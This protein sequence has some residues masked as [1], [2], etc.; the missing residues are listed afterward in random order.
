MSQQLDELPFPKMPNSG[1]ILGQ[2]HEAA[3][4]TS[5]STI[6]SGGGSPHSTRSYPSSEIDESPAAPIEGKRGVWCTD[7]DICAHSGQEAERA[8]TRWEPGDEET[9]LAEMLEECPGSTCYRHGADTWD[10]FQANET[11]FGV[12]STYKFDLSQYSTPLDVSKVPAR[13]RQKAERLAREIEE[14]RKGVDHHDGSDCDEDEEALWSSVPRSQCCST[15]RKSSLLGKMCPS[16]LDDI[17]EQG[18]SGEGSNSTSTRCTAVEFEQQKV[19][20]VFVHV[21]GVGIVD[22]HAV[23]SLPCFFGQP[24]YQVNAVPMNN[25]LS[26]AAPSMLGVG[27]VQM[28]NVNQMASS[29]TTAAH[30]ANTL[31]DCLPQGTQVVIDGLTKAPAFNGRSGV[32]QSFD[33]QSGR[34]NLQLLMESGGYQLAKVKLENLRWTLQPVCYQ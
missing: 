7:S 11:L 20:G 10:Q 9:E 4:S 23:R 2:D 21:D 25:V 17:D 6:A 15:K 13:T 16:H 27:S 12:E 5:Q 34:Y 29:A 33:A 32:V 14:G 18:L 22:E 3:D 1:R 24:S 19:Q 8:L 31:S 26:T 30:S 28:S